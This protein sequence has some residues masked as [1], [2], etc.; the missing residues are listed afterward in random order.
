M[1]TTPTEPKYSCGEAAERAGVSRS[2]WWRECQAGRVGFYTI[3]GR[4]VFGE[5]HISDYLASVEQKPGRQ[6]GRKV[7]AA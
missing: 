2:T 4:K 1:S 7:G 6:R 5:H 3:R